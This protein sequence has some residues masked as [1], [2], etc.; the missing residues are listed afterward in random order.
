[1]EEDDALDM[2]SSLLLLAKE[3]RAV[4]S[5]Q[6]GIQGTRVGLIYPQV[7]VLGKLD[8]NNLKS[9]EILKINFW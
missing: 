1:M 2:A 8:R 4:G 5:N 3:T 9:K 7:E 6:V